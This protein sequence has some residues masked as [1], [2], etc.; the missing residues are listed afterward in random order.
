MEKEKKERKSNVGESSVVNEGF[1]AA[2]V[3]V[4]ETSPKSLALLWQL[5]ARLFCS[6]HN[7]DSVSPSEIK[8]GHLDA[9]EYKQTRSGCCCCCS[10]LIF[11]LSLSLCADYTE[12]APPPS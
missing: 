1:P 12:F 10:R 5:V 2:C 9:S 6:P 11:F 3:C 8:S 7:L 4:C